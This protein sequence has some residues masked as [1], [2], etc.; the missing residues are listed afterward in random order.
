MLS[1]IALVGGPGFSLS[2]PLS[3]AEVSRKFA[4]ALHSSALWLPVAAF[5][6]AVVVS[7]SD[8]RFGSQEIWRKRIAINAFVGALVM[9]VVGFIN[10]EL[11]VS[12]LVAQHA[13]GAEL[14]Q[15][16]KK[17]EYLVDTFIAFNIGVIAFIL[18]IIV[19]LFEVKRMRVLFLEGKR[20]AIVTR[21]G[22]IF[23]VALGPNKKALLITAPQRD[24]GVPRNPIEGRFQQFPEGIA[25][26]WN[27]ANEQ[28]GGR[29]GVI[30]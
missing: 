19:Q 1:I 2:L 29:I 11:V 14:P 24:G 13:A 20:L 26:E 7:L 17:V 12:D 23:N 25:V 30:S 6:A 8:A 22:P 3:F 4:E 21:Q 5:M 15:E 16:V 27:G 10:T 28:V 18:C 9:T